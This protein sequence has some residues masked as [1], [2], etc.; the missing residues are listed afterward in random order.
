MKL[1]LLLTVVVFVLSGCDGPDSGK[2]SS[3][4]VEHPM[5]TPMPTP[6]LTFAELTERSERFLQQPKEKYE[7]L[8][9][10]DIERVMVG[11]K[12][13]DA[14]S[15]DRKKAEALHKKLNAL[16]VTIA[17]ERMVL[18]EKPQ[19]SEWDGSVLAVKEYLQNNLNDY[20]SSEF[21][22]WSTV[23]KIYVGKEPY[24]AVRLKLRAKNAFGALILRDTYYFMRKNTVIFSK[25]L[26][27]E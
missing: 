1:V 26:Q 7:D 13:V 9:V 20:S 14:K 27:N 21:V 23:T 24:W 18:G 15:K 12:E 6:T 8:N 19:N 2:R 10:A 22:E 4:K 5:P 11:L 16:V 3:I 17:T 25:G